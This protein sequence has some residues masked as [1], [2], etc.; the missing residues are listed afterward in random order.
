MSAWEFNAPDERWFHVTVPPSSAWTRLQSAAAARSALCSR[1]GRLS[2]LYNIANT[3]AVVKV[4]DAGGWV[5]ASTYIL[6]VY[7]PTTLPTLQLMAAST[8]WRSTER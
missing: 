3:E 2:I 8:A 4:P 1:A 7:T 6:T 5:P